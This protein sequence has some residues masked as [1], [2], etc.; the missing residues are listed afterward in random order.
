MYSCNDDH[1][2]VSYES[3]DCPVCNVLIDLED[4]ERKLGDL[5]D[6]ISDLQDLEL[7]LAAL[8]DYIRSY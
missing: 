5:K 6:S 7:K 8:K 3:G 1:D 4:A 2:K